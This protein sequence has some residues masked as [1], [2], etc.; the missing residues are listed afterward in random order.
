MPRQTSKYM[1]AKIIFELR[2]ER[3]LDCTQE[4]LARKLRVS[5]FSVSKWERGTIPAA[6]FRARIRKL[7]EQTGYSETAWPTISQKIGI[8][9]R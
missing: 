3:Y 1:W 9:K 4:S 7:A 6:Q 8:V 2:S 5:V